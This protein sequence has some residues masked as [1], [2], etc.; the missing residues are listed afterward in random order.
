MKKIIFILLLFIAFKADAQQGADTTKKKVN[1]ADTLKK[2][3]FTAPDT[4]RHLHGKFR[5][6]IPPMAMIGYGIGSFYIHPLR[7]FDHYVYDEAVEHDIITKSHLENYFQYAPVVLVYGL[8]LV[9]VHGKNTFVDRTLIYAMAQGML[10]LSLFGVK[11]ATH[12]LRPNGADRLSFA[13]GH[14][15]NA[16]AGAEFMSQELSEKSVA[17]SIIG[18]T[19]ATTTGIMRIYHQDHWFSDVVAGAGFGI[20][21]TKGAYLLYPYIRNAFSKEKKEKNNDIPIELKKNKQTKSAILMPSY[22]DG[23]VGFQFAMQL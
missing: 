8:N 15:G 11:N 21:S 7:H 18:Y 14:T 12:R 3:L 20:L 19:F 13:S 6:L 17:Y 16:F 4:V 10:T 5:S 1:V 23:A 2:D 9:G 22:Q